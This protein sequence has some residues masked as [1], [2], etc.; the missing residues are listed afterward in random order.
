MLYIE[1]D[2][3]MKSILLPTD[4]STVAKNALDFATQLA[5]RKHMEIKL[6]HVVERSDLYITAVTEGLHHQMNNVHLLRLLEKVKS[7]LEMICGELERKEIPTS[8]QIKIG[9]PF[10]HISDVV[11]NQ[12]CDLIVMGAHGASGFDQWVFGTTAERILRSSSCPVIILKEATILNEIKKVVF[13]YY[14]LAAPEDQSY[15]LKAVQDL[16][17]GEIYLV[18]INVP[19]NFICQRD[20]MMKLA[21]FARNNSIHN[22]HS[23][24]YNDV[25]EEAGLLHYAED[26]KAD[27]VVIGSHRRG[28]LSH[29]FSG[30]ITESLVD[31]IALP[32]FSF[33]L[34]Q[35]PKSLNKK[36]N[37]YD[38]Q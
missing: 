20:G 28:A 8:Y 6:L 26:I 3:I 33:P 29:I 15:M 2:C 12:Q 21:D 7:Q 25:T 37:S 32:V 22:F 31:H 4:F 17:G 27:L 23:F 13:P 36:E 16:F 35:S 9:H 38:H 19:G 10:H 24:I 30:S 11:K 1:A 5:I 14:S 34:G 18:T